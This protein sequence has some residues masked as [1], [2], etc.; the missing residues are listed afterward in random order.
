MLLLI[1]QDMPL[2]SIVFVHPYMPLPSFCPSSARAQNG[3][4]LAWPTPMDTAAAGAPELSGES[5]CFL[6]HL[7]FEQGVLLALGRA[8]L[9]MHVLT[10]GT[11][12][13]G[14]HTKYFLRIRAASLVIHLSRCYRCLHILASTCKGMR[15]AIASIEIAHCTVKI[16]EISACTAKFMTFYV[17]VTFFLQD[18]SLC[19]C[20]VLQRTCLILPTA[21]DWP[22]HSLR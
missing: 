5:D 15:A 8:P 14:S 20:S 11:S 22:G 1:A 13:L 2:V 12:S 6:L 3:S 7:S 18:L 9:S 21:T 16:N 10:E 19:W 4:T 17:V